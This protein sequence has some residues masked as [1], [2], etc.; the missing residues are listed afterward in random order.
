MFGSVCREG[1]QARI[2]EDYDFTMERGGSRIKDYREENFDT[3]EQGDFTMNSENCCSFT[4]GEVN[5]DAP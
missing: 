4:S 1:F 2:R 5:Y 3:R